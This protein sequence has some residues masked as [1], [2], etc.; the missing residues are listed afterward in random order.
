MERRG[1]DRDFKALH[2]DFVQQDEYKSFRNK[3]GQDGTP[4]P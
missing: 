3:N 2:H 1:H 4:R